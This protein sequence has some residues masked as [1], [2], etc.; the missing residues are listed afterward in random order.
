MSSVGYSVMGVECPFPAGGA[1]RCSRVR[2]Q[3]EL[4]PLDCAQCCCEK[5]WQC[6]TIA[7]KFTVLGAAPVAAA[8]PLR[9]FTDGGTVCPVALLLCCPVALLPRAP[10]PEPRCS[11]IGKVWNKVPCLFP[12]LFLASFLSFPLLP[13]VFLRFPCLFLAFSFSFSRCQCRMGLQFPFQRDV[14]LFASSF[15]I[16]GVR[17]GVSFRK[18]RKALLSFHLRDCLERCYDRSWRSLFE[19]FTFK[20]QADDAR[21]HI[22][23]AAQQPLHSVTMRPGEPVGQ[24]AF[25]FHSSL[26]YGVL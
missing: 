1:G 15:S 8:P 17:F 10:S 23:S 19:S 2:T 3:C 24:R 14:S 26:G 18:V 9:V 12:C 5:L 21:W 11:R 6:D 20:V 25:S 4:K 22:H 7:S 13:C 16:Y